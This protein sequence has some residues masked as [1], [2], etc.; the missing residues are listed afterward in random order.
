M[1]QNKEILQHLQT[2]NLLNPLQAL[3]KFG[4]FRLSARINDLRNEGHSIE[5]KMIT[6]GGKTFAQYRLP[7]NAQLSIEGFL[8]KS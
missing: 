5:S 4:C 7:M 2:G 3:N 6:V 8:Q 1:T